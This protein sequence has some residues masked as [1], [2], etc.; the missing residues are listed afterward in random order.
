MYIVLIVVYHVEKREDPKGTSQPSIKSF[1]ESTERQQPLPR[2]NIGRTSSTEP[3]L[4][5]NSLNRRTGGVGGDTQPFVTHQRQPRP[6]D[7]NAPASLPRYN[8]PNEREYPMQTR[9]RSE[10]GESGD[11]EYYVGR[12]PEHEQPLQYVEYFTSV[13]TFL[14]LG[15]LL[16]DFYSCACILMHHYLTFVSFVYMDLTPLHLCFAYAMLDE[17]FEIISFY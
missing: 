13:S 7:V 6:G 1:E 9:K 4:R 3:I 8:R 5:D 17:F 14:Y 16:L 10:P 11:V 12:S 15:R 2:R